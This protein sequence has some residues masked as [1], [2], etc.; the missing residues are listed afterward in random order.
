MTDATTALTNLRSAIVSAVTE[1]DSFPLSDSFLTAGMDTPDVVVPE[2]LDAVLAGAFQLVDTILNV[3]CDTNAVEPLVNGTFTISGAN[4]PVIALSSTCPA[5]LVFSSTSDADGNTFLVVQIASKPSNWNWD[6]SFPNMTGWPFNQ[7]TL[8]SARYYYSSATGFYPWNDTTGIAVVDG[9]KQ[10]LVARLTVPASISPYLTLFAGLIAPDGLIDFGGILDL[11]DYGGPNFEDGALYPVGVFTGALS[12][13]SYTFVDYLSVTAPSIMLDL[14]IITV[15]DDEETDSDVDEDLDEETA[16]DEDVSYDQ[17]PNLGITSALSV[18]GADLGTYQLNVMVFYTADSAPT[19]YAVSLLPLSEKTLTPSAAIELI[20][21]K[22]SYFDGTPQI[23]QQFLT[24]FG[25][26]E[27]TINGTLYDPSGGGGLNVGQVTV[28]LSTP[29]DTNVGWKPLP[30]PTSNPDFSFI[31]NS[32]SLNW[33][34]SDPLGSPSFYYLFNTTFSFLPSVFKASDGNDG[35]FDVSFDSDLNFSATFPGT[36]SLTD[37][38]DTVSGGYV[39]L[40]D[41]IEAELSD[42]SLQLDYSGQTFSFDCGI[43][44]NLSFVQINGYDVLTISN[45]SISLSAISGSDDSGTAWASQF[46]GLVNI[47]GLAANVTIG[48]DGQ[49]DTTGWSLTASL[50][51][52]VDVGEVIKQF[53]SAGGSYDFPS[54]LDFELEVLSFDISAFI[55]SDK[56]NSTTYSV[57]TTFYWEFS[58]GDQ[59]VQLQDAALAVAYDGDGYSG[60]ASATWVY[61]SINL[62]L[63]FGYEFEANGNKTLFVTWEGFT[64]TY[65][66]SSDPT[67]PQQEITF[68]LKGWS[69][70]TLI[71]SLVGTLGDPYFSLPSPWDLL[72]QISLD[73]LS[74]TVSLKN[75]ATDCLTGSYTLSN[76]LNLGFII[77]KG[78]SITRDTNKQVRLALDATAPPELQSSLGSLLEPE[79]QSVQDMPAVTGQGSDYFKLNLLALGQRIAIAGS[80]SFNSTQEV[81]AALKDVPETSG[82]KN[83]VVPTNTTP[84]APYYNAGSNWLI[85]LDFNVLK[86]GG[87]WFI[88][89]QIVF[90]DPNLYGLHLT[91]DGGKSG[92]LKGFDLDILYKKISDDIGVFQIDFTFPDS[93][94]NL[95]FGAV[96]VVLPSIGIQIFTNGDFTIDLGFPY[97]MD[98][99]KS[100]SVSAIIAGVPVLGSGGVYF[101]KLSNATATQVPQTDLGTFNPVILIGIGLQ[102][103]LGYNFTEGPLSAGFALTEFGIIEGV[104]ATYHPYDTSNSG[105]GKAVQDT[106][107]FYLKGTVGLIGMLYGTVDFKI[108]TASVLVNLTL[109][110][111]ITYESFEPIDINA[112]ASVKVSVKV[113]IN[114]GLFSIKISLSYHTTVSVTFT[115]NLPDSGTAPWLSSGTQTN[116]TML[117]GST[118]TANI[119]GRRRRW[120][121]RALPREALRHQPKLYARS[122]RPARVAMTTADKE[123]LTLLVAPQFTILAPESST[124]YADQEG[125]F[126][127]Q[128]A[129]DSPDPTATSDDTQDAV[130]SSFEKMCASFFPWLIDMMNGETATQIN[131]TETTQQTVTVT[132]LHYDLEWIADPSNT[133]FTPKDLLT[134]LSDSFIVNIVTAAPADETNHILFPL[135]DGLTL[136]IPNPNGGTDTKTITLETYVTA[137]N[138][139]C[140]NAAQQL[141]EVAPTSASTDATIQTTSAAEDNA[142]SMAS[143]MFVDTYTIIARALLQAAINAFDNYAYLV[144]DESIAQILTALNGYGNELTADDISVPNA[145]YDLNQGAVLNIAGLTDTI[146]TGDTLSTIA[147]RYS[148]PDTGN[149][150]WSTSASA[151][152]TSNGDARILQTN[153]KLNLTING[154]ATIYTTVPGDSFNQ[155]ANACGITLE[156]LAQQSSLWET[157]ALLT[158]ATTI[159]IAP[160]SYTTALQDTLDIIANTFGTTVSQIAA[161]NADVSGLFIQGHIAI[162]A[163][164]ELLI[165]DVWGS[166]I[167]TSEIAQAGGQVASFLAAGLRLPNLDG[168]SLSPDFMYPTSQS[169]YSLAQLSGQQFPTSVKADSYNITLG[170]ADTSHDVNMNFITFGDDPTATSINVS[171]SDAY[172]LLETVLDYAQ[173]GKFIPSPTY[174]NEPLVQLQ[175]RQYTSSGYSQ[176]NTSDYAQLAQVTENSASTSS[177]T[178]Y[179]WSLPSSLLNGL[180]NRQQ[181]LGSVFNAD[182]QYE[183]IL[184]LMPSYVPQKGTTSPNDPSTVFSDLTAYSYTTRVDFQIT[185]LSSS[186]ASNSTGQSASTSAVNNANIYQLVGPSANDTGYLERLLTALSALGNDL[187][188]DLFLL[189]N[190]GGSNTTALTGQAT[191]EFLSFITQTNLSTQSNPTFSTVFAMDAVT[192]TAPPPRGI[193]NSPVEFITLLWEQSVVK[194]GGYYF[195][196]EQIESGTGLPAEIFD[197]NGTATLTMV[198]TIK[199]GLTINAGD[200]LSNFINSF[201]T[202]ENIDPQNDVVVVQSQNTSGKSAPLSGDESLARIATTYGASLNALATSNSTTT[203]VTGTAIPVSGIL[204]QLTAQETQNT[205]QTLANLAAY[206]SVGAQAPITASDISSYNPGVTIATGAS[207]A[208][209][210]ITYVVDPALSAGPGTN[211][212][213]MAGYYALSIEALAVLAATIEKLFSSGTVLVINTLSQDVMATQPP[214]NLSFSIERANLG[215]PE[216]P[217]SNATQQELD[218]FS[219][220]TLYSLYNTLSGSLA[221]NPYFNASPFG[222]PFGPQDTGN[223]DTD[224][225]ASQSGNNLTATATMPG[226]R[227]M[228]R[229]RKNRLSPRASANAR[230]ESLSALADTNTYNYS[231]VLG[232]AGSSLPFAKI[233]PAPATPATGLPPA[234][235][236]PYIGIGSYASIALRWQDLY[237][238]I[239]VTPFDLAPS[240]YTGAL[241][242][243]PSTL[244]YIDRLTGIALWPKTKYSYIYSGDAGAPSLN[245]NLALDAQAYDPDGQSLDVAT[246]DLATYQSIYF[247]L[248]QDYSGLGVTGVSGNAVTMTV[249]NSLLNEPDKVLDDSQSQIVRDFVSECI[250]FLQDYITNG[251]LPANAPQTTLVLAVSIDDIV[252]KNLIELDVSLTL[253]R[254]PILVEPLIAGIQDGLSVT[255]SIPPFANNS[256][257]AQPTSY[258]TFATA[259]ET[260][261]QTDSWAMR[262]GAGLS[263]ATSGTSSQTDQIYAVRFG[264]SSE[265]GIYFKIAPDAGYYAPLPISTSLQSGTVTLNMY[266]NGGGQSQQ[267]VD[268][269]SIDLNL[270]FSSCLDALD[271][272]LSA[273]Y[274]PHAFI[275]DQLNG[276]EDPLEDG[277]LGAILTAKQNFADAISAT[278]TAILSNSATDASTIAAAQNSMKQQLLTTLG[279]AFDAGTVIVFRLDD[280]SGADTIGD[281]GPPYLFG[282]P[283]GTSTTGSDTDSNQNF[284][285]SS[286]TV[287]LADVEKNAPRLAYNLTT[288]NVDTQ[289]YIGLNMSYQITHMAFDNALVPG[290]KDYVDTSWLVFINPITPNK[291]GAQDIPVLNRALPIPP[292]VQTQTALPANAMNGLST[293]DLTPSQLATWDYSFTYNY[294]AAAQDDISI[295]IT[296]NSDGN[297]TL[298][299]STTGTSALFNTLADFVTNYATISADLD[300]YLVKINAQTTD[301][302]LIDKATAAVSAL[303]SRLTAVAAAY[304]DQFSADMMMNADII[305]QSTPLTFDTKLEADADGNAMV[306]LRNVCIDDIPVTY[307]AENG[308]IGNGSV[309]LSPPVIEILADQYTATLVSSP[310][311]GVILAYSYPARQNNQEDEATPLTFEQ[312]LQETNRTVSLADLNVM[313]YQNAR[314]ALFTQRNTLL[315]PSEETGDVTTNNVFLYQTPEVTFSD[316]ILPTI[317]WPNYALKQI[318]PVT[319]SSVT[320]Y[321]SAFFSD[322]FKG[323]SGT[324]KLGM[325]GGYSYS[326]APS[327]TTLPK[328][329]LPINLLQPVDTII[330]PSSPPAE[331]IAVAQQIEDWFLASQPATS[332]GSAMNFKVDLFSDTHSSQLLFRINNLYFSTEE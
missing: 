137:T 270:W 165:S 191:S 171:L 197:T 205:S 82:S 21:G 127:C 274:A 66:S 187:I 201:V 225:A 253:A 133:L 151:L 101:G 307:S 239:T 44:V 238:N 122:P 195:Y 278:T 141:R 245:F 240:T 55:P 179:L 162:A 254:N 26:S 125:A 224:N 313:V 59:S 3:N 301:Q 215:T 323:A 312:A 131:L 289:S 189:Y 283:M 15:P 306:C 166:I 176:W 84:G 73:G 168:L 93:I 150:R 230:S 294:A 99:S 65:L 236:N 247:Q 17:N 181:R 74:V 266:S 96:S 144:T 61:P 209:P 2:N 30:N 116:R 36:A 250:V 331:A 217:P 228:K 221:E 167:T 291:L 302:T 153:V 207:F 95:N 161:Q 246:Q 27:M 210:P 60:S 160:I 10:T 86:T 317:T 319:G 326:V 154:E 185:R 139:Y 292:T 170:R 18:E 260:C 155:I 48:Y 316:P 206:Y 28:V 229:V 14:S 54:F 76:P 136:T 299:D 4:V 147:S 192:D 281:G 267:I 174:T 77:V 152:I 119:G 237:G 182:Q 285:L 226:G 46:G 263:P 257:P 262:T 105:T 214:G 71:S 100:F 57:D 300:A 324:L 322:L 275:L 146:Q 9:T 35:Q 175:P 286:A 330:D 134:F 219:E 106:N 50:A 158:A 261:L 188:T 126:V 304:S 41:S 276:T 223:G 288:K 22:G 62:S 310:P 178:P 256:D 280:V 72:N 193:A 332:T 124:S 6:T 282:Q 112:S 172:S 113:K 186:T 138:S 163:L 243:P 296:L 222:L 110:V 321:M 273:T 5:D 129:M 220:T 39:I 8:A 142:Q 53:F 227:T 242:N 94:R 248:N 325:N 128:F 149:S 190:A 117:M 290:I 264:T 213:S 159:L 135:F 279:S 259:L 157:P 120:R 43:S 305:V 19:T 92:A 287:P 315:T 79:G 173:A 249:T 83:P 68:T 295:T 29:A 47:C 75:G 63:E 51:E 81:I 184:D 23:L 102:M 13:K 298:S 180:A 114:L 200:T 196:W 269:S 314:S 143:Y 97:D 56:N 211:F 31:I 58:F 148:D 7:V 103:G 89:A 271:K 67:N 115:I 232:F 52:P 203:I 309:T 199:P 11:T 293:K 118:D 164:D 20:G 38:L 212:A 104:F 156:Q 91:L 177:T 216:T 252:S 80:E 111:S 33:T 255:T 318:V 40:P 107:Y 69:L 140:A 70:G 98:F 85:A 109:S 235:D 311:S 1:N 241:N 265:T 208:I 108:I 34:A 328:T 320:D 32:F 132:K 268:F 303:Q 272:F 194:G 25:L 308:T 327:I 45:G 121:S 37:F 277:M 123:T 42:I 234:S 90:N 204:H 64:A 130:N 24:S 233:N 145:D 284:T 49:S 231:Q 16:E 297:N 244:R 329:Y 258:T 88:S 12:T 251:K 87:V 202:T 169:E 78:L 183:D 198:A 218:T